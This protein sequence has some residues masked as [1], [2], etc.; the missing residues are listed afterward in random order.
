M[1]FRIH[2]KKIDDLKKG[3][4]PIYEPGLEAMMRRNIEDKRI[5]IFPCFFCC[6][7]Y[8]FIFRSAWIVVFINC[9]I[10]ICISFW[11]QVSFIIIG[12]RCCSSSSQGGQVCICLADYVI[13]TVIFIGGCV[14]I[15]ISLCNYV[16]CKVVS[17][18]YILW[19]FVP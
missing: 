10:A 1:L 18:N 16:S 13:C 14:S 3:I 7:A 9:S 4:L 2:L 8:T 15:R 12:K 6:K 5:I 11:G 17:C 19:S